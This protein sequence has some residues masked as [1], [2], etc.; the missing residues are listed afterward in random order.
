MSDVKPKYTP[1][2]YQEYILDRI[3]EYKNTNLL[4]ELDCG[5]G[6]RF[7]T[8]QLVVDRFPDARFIIIV[9][10]SSSLAETVDYLK[11][12]YGGLEEDLGEISSR[13]RSGIRKWILK[14]K[15]VVVATPQTLANIVKRNRDIIDGFN[16]ILIN[17]VD[18]LVRR[19]SGRT[20]LVFPWP[21]LLAHMKEKWIIGMSGT[22]RDDHA[23]FTKEQ[24]EIRKELNTLKRYIKNSQVISMEDLYG[25]DL[26]EYLEPTFLTMKSVTDVRI[27][28]ISKVLDELIRSTRSEIFHQLGEEDSLHLIEGD[29]RRVHMMLERLPI[30]EELKS[31]YSGLL[32]LR[33]YVYAMPPKRFL[34]MFHND[35]MKHYF[36]VSELQRL[37]PTISA[38]VTKAHQLIL[39]RQ[40]VV[41]LSSYISMVNQMKR[42]LEKSNIQVLTITGKTRDKGKVLQEFRENPE[43]RALVMSPVGERDLDIPQAEL[44][45]ILDA[46]NTSK[47]MYQK[48]KRTRGGLV[49]L[50]AYEGTSEER[51]MRRLMDNILEKYPWSTAVLDS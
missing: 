51:K 19:S 37:L 23:V 38:K 35:Y 43:A 46:I 3:E 32:M 11:G 45:I 27:R 22:L 33:K 28:S 26:E 48:F 30:T 41:I 14:E 2:G 47:T 12:E 29:A 18:T 40:K 9:H 10:S 20:A 7:I 6:K 4:L 16:I 5:L 39:Q 21:T 13:V 24:V 50:L 25:T 31:R 8:H 34:R 44:M 17:E 36:N 49:V 15:R 1:R 42:V